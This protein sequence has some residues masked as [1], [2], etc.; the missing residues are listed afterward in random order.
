MKILLVVIGVL[1][2]AAVLLPQ[3][4]KAAD[5]YR[6]KID[7]SLVT[8]FDLNGKPVYNKKFNFPQ[9][10]S[11]DLDGDGINE[12]LVEDTYRKGINTYYIL[13]I[14]N[15]IDTFSLA[16]SVVSGLRAPYVTG[17][18]DAGGTIIVTGNPKFDSFNKDTSDIFV[19]VNCWMFENGELFNVNDEVYNLFIRESEGIMDF[20]DSYPESDAKNCSS[21]KILEAAIASGYVNYLNAGEKILAEQFIKKYYKCPDLNE[22]KKK[23]KA[24]L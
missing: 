8:A 7:N 10:F 5:N 13:Y 6:I 4:K 19:P 11:S 1:T 9:S 15:T 20:I 2:G 3:N 17:S 18:E 24:L 14:F 22:F 21:S 12:V 23:I 16:D